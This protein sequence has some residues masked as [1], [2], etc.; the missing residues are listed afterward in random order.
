MQGDGRIWDTFQT[1]PPLE[2]E[3]S[4]LHASLNTTV[5]LALSLFH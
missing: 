3:P 4:Y 5:L 2:A 1:S